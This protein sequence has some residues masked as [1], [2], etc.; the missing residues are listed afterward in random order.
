VEDCRKEMEA[1]HP[2]DWFP[3]PTGI[4]P[5]NPNLDRLTHMFVESDLKTSILGWEWRGQL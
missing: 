2:E 5:P 4:Y 1:N 3:V